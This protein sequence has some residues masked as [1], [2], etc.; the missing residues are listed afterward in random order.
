MFS[1]YKYLIVYLVFFPPRFLEL[2]VFLIAPFPDRCLLVPFHTSGYCAVMEASVANR[3]I[4][5]MTYM[6]LNEN[7]LPV[8]FKNIT[9]K[10]KCANS[11]FSILIHDISLYISESCYD[12]HQKGKGDNLYFLGRLICAFVFAYG[13]LHQY[14]GANLIADNRK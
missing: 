5:W 7:G 10:Y 4:N 12:F 14:Y 2:N 3:P 11:N 13:K 1:W 6:L 9:S 8:S